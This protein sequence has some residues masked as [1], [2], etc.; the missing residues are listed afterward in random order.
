[1]DY[2]IENN[3]A[4]PDIKYMKNKIGHDITMLYEKSKEIALK[5]N[6]SF[7]YL[8]NLDS[9]IHTDMLHILSSFAKGDRYS[10]IDFVTTQNRTSDPI[11]EWFQ[12]V[13]SLL[14][15]GKVPQRKRFSIEYN[16]Q[17]IERAMSQISHSTIY[18]NEVGLQMTHGEASYMTGM[19]EAILKYR[20]LYTIQIIRYW[21][22]IT[23]S[24]QY[25]AMSQ[26]FPEQNIPFFSEIFSCFYNDDRYILK[27]KKFDS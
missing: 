27:Y 17:V 23:N 11:K 12:K 9:Q 10:N 2:H 6:I 13:D 18:I 19:N 15:I 3:G 1:L 22:E 7:S 4:F 24:L 20:R 21:V 25:K 16:A 8:K 26:T 14:F 5:H